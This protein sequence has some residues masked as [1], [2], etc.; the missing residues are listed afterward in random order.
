MKVDV[1]VGGTALADT[2]TAT[3]T[4]TFGYMTKTVT[5]NGT[6]AK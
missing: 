4:L 6:V 5:V 2:F 1:A 3:V